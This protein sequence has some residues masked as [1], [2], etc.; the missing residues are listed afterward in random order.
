PPPRAAAGARRARP[1][2]AQAGPGRPGAGTAPPPRRR[3]RRRHDRPAPACS[4]AK[5]RA[6]AAAVTRCAT[7]RHS[8]AQAMV[9]TPV[10]GVGPRPG[11]TQRWTGG[12]P[13]W[14][15]VMPGLASFLGVR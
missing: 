2:G 9:T 15:V 5:A 13:P 14:A 10:V 11:L 6:R 8:T 4:A 7:R 3:P 1:P 12:Y